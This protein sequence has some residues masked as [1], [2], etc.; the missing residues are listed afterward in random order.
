MS[1]LDQ[2]KKPAAQPPV[3]TIV[4]FPGVGKSTLGALFPSPV[5]IQAENTSTAFEQWDQE[6]APALM[7]ELPAASRQRGIRPSEVLIA[8]LRELVTEKHPYRTVVVDAITTANILFEQEII[9]FSQSP[10]GDAVTNIGEAEGGYGK[11]YLAVAGIH[12]K[13]RNAA[14][15]LRR[16]GLGVVFLAH[17]GM[18]KVKN[19]PDVEPYSTWS[20]DMHEASRRVYVATSDAVLYLQSREYVTGTEVDRKGKQ[21]KLGKIRATGERFL[22]TCSAGTV[23]FVD[24]KNRYNLPAE[25]P[26]NQGEN[27]LIQYIPYYAKGDNHE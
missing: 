15:H 11:G 17:T 8:Q 5:F 10:N 23:G 7:P 6:M 13:I 22:V 12:A 26:V 9:E 19:R 4:G 1:Y 20:I 16:K 3:I 2:I 24:A 25:I 27:P 18:A 21:T 14:E